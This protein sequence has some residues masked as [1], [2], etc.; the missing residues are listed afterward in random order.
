MPKKETKYEYTLSRHTPLVT[1][2]ELAVLSTLVSVLAFTP[3][4]MPDVDEVLV[5]GVTFTEELGG[6]VVVGN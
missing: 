5:G 4:S 1:G 2:L 6:A 3:V